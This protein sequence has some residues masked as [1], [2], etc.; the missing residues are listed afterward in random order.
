MKMISV[1][2]PE[3][4]DKQK[5]MLGLTWRGVIARGLNAEKYMEEMRKYRQEYE[6]LRESNEKL[7]RRFNRV[8]KELQE[9]KSQNI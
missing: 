3:N 5:K 1:V 7:L 9:L 6:E 8:M 2:I 4:F